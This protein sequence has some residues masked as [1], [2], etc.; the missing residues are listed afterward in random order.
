[1]ARSKKSELNPLDGVFDDKQ[2]EAVKQ[3]VQAAQLKQGVKG[4]PFKRINMG[5]TDENHAFI[6]LEGRKQGLWPSQFVNKI[7]DEY[8]KEYD[9]K[10]MI[11]D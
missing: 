2:S 3:R 8:R 11:K 5:F 1:M 7:L 10:K 9:K 4:K 6:T